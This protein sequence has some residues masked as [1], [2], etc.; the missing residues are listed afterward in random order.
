MPAALTIAAGLGTRLLHIQAARKSPEA[1]AAVGTVLIVQ[2]AAAVTREQEWL[3]LHLG[4]SASAAASAAAAHAS[5]S[6]FG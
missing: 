4:L 3:L 1:S 5:V 6:Q 2:D